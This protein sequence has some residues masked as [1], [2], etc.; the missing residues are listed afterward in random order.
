MPLAFQ[1]AVADFSSAQVLTLW[2]VAMGIAFLILVSLAG[3][4]VPAWVSVHK[5]RLDT[6]LKQQM[7]ERGMSAEEIVRVLE[8]RARDRTSVNY[9]SAS[10]VVVESEGEWSPG[11]ILQR[12]G[13]RYLVHYVGYDMSDNE[14]VTSDRVR[15]PASSK[16]RCGS[17]W[18]WASS[19]GTFDA[20]HWCANK[21]K[22][23][24]V[25]ADL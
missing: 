17:P 9:P 22:P 18:D 2:I 5:A 3:I 20:S 6:A 7:L 21:S 16:E 24:P 25:D 8:G 11:F 1:T 4:I 19:A 12:E 14:W 13:D 23:A 15:F 10:E